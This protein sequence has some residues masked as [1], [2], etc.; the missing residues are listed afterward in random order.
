MRSIGLPLFLLFILC[1]CTLFDDNGDDC[2][3]FEITIM[4][5]ENVVSP[6]EHVRLTVTVTNTSSTRFVWGHGS[7]GCQLGV[8]VRVA[9]TDLIALG[10]RVC[11][12]DVVEQGL[13]PGESRSETWLWDGTVV[14]NELLEYLPPG[15]YDLY[16]AA[17]VWL[18]HEH[19][20]IRVVQ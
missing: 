19:V 5:D 17:G 12:D 4:A 1:C 8:V 16:G 6:E 2:Q 20:R 13:D 18:S 14:E 9:D 7:S 15:D 11:T 3:K 10:D